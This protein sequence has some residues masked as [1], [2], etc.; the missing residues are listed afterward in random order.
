MQSSTT[1]PALLTALQDPAFYPHQPESVQVI[2]THIS[3]VF[4]AGDLVYKIKKPVNFGFLDFSTREK[5][6]HYCQEELRLNRRLA[7]SVYREVVAF[8]RDDRGTIF[9][10][11]GPTVIDYAVVM[12]RIP[13][14]RMLSALLPQGAVDIS[15]MDRLART[16]CTFHQSAETGGEIDEIGGYDTIRHN[17]EEN[18]EQ[19]KNAIGVT[20][21]EENFTRISSF[22]L[23]FLDTH[24]DLFR[25][26]VAGHR[27]RDC[28]GDLHVQHI[29]LTDPL[30]IF[31]CIEFNK[32]F[33]YL[34]VAAECAFLAMDLDFNGYHRFADAFVDAYI[35]HSGDADIRR[36]LPFYQCYFA[37]VR[38]KV[39]GFTIADPAVPAEE[40][41]KARLTAS[42]YF[43]CALGYASSPPHASLIIMCGLMGTGK[44][45][46][47]A[48]IAAPLGATVI[49]LDS[50]RK[51]MLGIPKEERHLEDFGQGIYA[52]EITKQTY[53]EARRRASGL[54]AAGRSVIIDGSFKRRDERRA[55][56]SLAREHRADF[57]AVECR[58][59]D[60]CVRERLC[61]RISDD[62][63]VSDGRWELYSNQKDDFDNVNEWNTANHIVIDTNNSLDALR[64]KVVSDITS[65]R[66]VP[67]MGVD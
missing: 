56:E 4:I 19:T 28:H 31:D 62:T 35:A 13:E 49:T 50:L 32:R 5:R 29:C 2:Q 41:E 30:V 63:E 51:E 46:L 58:C 38:G 22:A 11:E 37:Y 17:H 61:G 42:R 10:G 48:A 47:A 55:A 12:R 36:L 9:I 64:K 14:E 34:D 66:N 18:F 23:T 16:I 15:V 7:E 52:P 26:R 57:F 27:I 67:H 65:H 53:D 59:S 8:S 43:D 39:I 6:R 24:E 40:K 45:R 25:S 44:S 20:L 21:S 60:E 1:D 54:L 3:F 33:R